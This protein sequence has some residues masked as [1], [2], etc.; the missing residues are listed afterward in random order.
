MDIKT[1]F[2]TYIKPVPEWKLNNEACA[3]YVAM[4]LATQYEERAAKIRTEFP[5]MQEQFI[6]E[7]I[8]YYAEREFWTQ[9][10]A[11]RS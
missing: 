2:K 3:R 5:R 6:A 9:L 1:W 10:R 8:G 7:H 4:V 11:S